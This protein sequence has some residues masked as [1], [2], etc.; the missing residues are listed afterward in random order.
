M[1]P[2]IYP[3]VTLYTEAPDN[4][5]NTFFLNLEFNLRFYFER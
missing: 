4:F 3:T 2:D 5:H 1:S